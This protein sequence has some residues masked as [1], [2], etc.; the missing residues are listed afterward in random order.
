MSEHKD[1]IRQT[2]LRALRHGISIDEWGGQLEESC[3]EYRSLARKMQT[4]VDFKLTAAER[5]TLELLKGALALR[6]ENIEDINGVKGLM[7]SELKQIVPCLEGIFTA[8]PVPFPLDLTRFGFE[9]TAHEVEKISEE[10]VKAR[11][12][13]PGRSKAQGRIPTGHRSISIT[14]NSIGLKDAQ[15]YIDPFIAVSVVAPSG[16]VLETKNTRKSNRSEHQFITYD[17]EIPLKYTIEQFIKGD[18]ALFFEF[19]HFK[20]KKNKVSTRCYAF[21]ER[22]EIEACV[23]GQIMALELYKK[24][25]DL[26]RKRV[27]LF[28]VKQLFLHVTPLI[29]VN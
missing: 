3:D 16:E 10:R 25:T 7:L 21:L 20:P 11:Q 22:K 27:Q 6:I 17:D 29:T 2:W 9:V 23:S 19:N 14:V 12:E 5:S 28:T 15:T 18:L 13:R 8:N 1:V 24:P 26:T 4:D